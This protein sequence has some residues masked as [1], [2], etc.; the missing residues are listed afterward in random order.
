MRIGIIIL[1]AGSSS[2]L[3]QSKQ[4][5]LF[6]NKS[7]LRRAAEVSLSTS[8]SHVIV[9]LGSEIKTH[10]KVIDDLSL[11]IVSNDLWE[12]GMGSSLKTGLRYLLEIDPDTEAVIIL[13][14]DQPHLTSGILN[15]L[16]NNYRQTQAPVI[17][18]AYA[19]TLGVPA[20]F[21]KTTFARLLTIDD[22]QGAKKIL[23]QYMPVKTISFPEGAL[24][25]DT[26][27][28]LE[29]LTKHSGR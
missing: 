9:V 2:R 12:N 4:L 11:K 22:K 23:Q 20:L 28:D 15:S 18:S 21:N 29:K 27:E 7:L 1:A 5:V 13:V 19:D 26:P 10:R 8:T 6:E 24:D 3:G 14:C 17:A 16:L 25:I